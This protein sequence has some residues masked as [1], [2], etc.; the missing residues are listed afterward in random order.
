M[1][2][3]FRSAVI[4]AFVFCGV[5]NCHMANGHEG[6]SAPTYRVTAAGKRIAAGPHLRLRITDAKSKVEIA[7][8]FSLSVD[9]DVYVPAT[10]GKHGLRFVSIHHRRKEHFIAT[11]ARGTGEILIPLPQDAVKGRVTVVK[12][13]E[14]VPQTIA[15]HVNEGSAAANV[16]LN[17]WVNLGEEGWR[18]ADEH[19]HYARTHRKHDSDW[20]TML[21]ADGLAHAHFLVLKGGNIDGIWAEQY[22]FGKQGEAV[23]GERL[24]RSGEEFRCNKQG[25]INLLGIDEVIPPISIGGLGSSSSPFHYPPLLDVLRRTHELGGIG[26]PA[27][28]GALSSASTAILDTILGQVDFF[29]IANTHLFNT[30]VWYLLL[31]CGFIVPPVA[32][33]DLPN[34]GFRDPWQPFLG[35]VRTYVRVGEE[36]SFSAWKQAIGRSETFVTSGPVIRMAVNGVGPGGTIRL[37]KHGGKLTILAE[38]ASPRRLSKLQVISMG[39][40]LGINF[41]RTQKN[42]IN[43]LTLSKTITVK[44]SCWLAAKGIGQPKTAIER[45][46]GRKQ[47]V[48]AHTAAVKVIVGD[49]PIS[50]LESAEKLRVQLLV[51]QEFFKTQGAFQQADHRQRFVQLF[52]KA[53]EKLD[54]GLKSNGQ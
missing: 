46:L 19:L 43:R 5:S 27:H 6:H 33:T 21:D 26:G 36:S 52:D 2:W 39:K 25:H 32:G 13:F 44:N 3:S 37:P 4:S 16:G 34:Y 42:G 20:L 15:F 54:A 31:N 23:D 29:E 17:R 48:V 1:V 30:D 49:Q 10:L 18:A 12:G 14:Y 8:R 9:D 40:P 47:P 45:R 41:T 24:I 51:Q 28:G 38:L 7:A 11:Y 35:E 50:S 22:A 53:I